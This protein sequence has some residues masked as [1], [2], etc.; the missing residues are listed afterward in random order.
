MGDYLP[1]ASLLPLVLCQFTDRA[2][3]YFRPILFADSHIVL[4]VVA[5]RLASHVGER[6]GL[7]RRANRP[8]PL[9]PDYLAST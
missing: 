5:D 9:R 1:L 6:R 2:R 7:A 8:R 4:R 3:F